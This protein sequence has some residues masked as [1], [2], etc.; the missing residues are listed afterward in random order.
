MAI[1]ITQEVMRTDEF[2]LVPP[3]R[4]QRNTERHS[5]RIVDHLKRAPV[6]TT[7]GVAVIEYSDGSREV[8]DGNSRSYLWRNGRLSRPQSVIV[9]VYHVDTMYEAQSVYFSYNNPISGKDARD[10]VVNS[11]RVHGW[12]PKSAYCQAATLKSPILY[13]QGN[14]MGLK[15]PIKGQ[16]V[17]P[18]LPLWLNELRIFDEILSNGKA[19]GRT[20]TPVVAAC[21]MTLRRH[22]EM[23]IPFWRE[24]FSDGWRGGGID[25]PMNKLHGYIKDR[26]RNFSSSTALYKHLEVVVYIFER[27]LKGDPVIQQIR[28]VSLIDGAYG[29]TYCQGQDSTEEPV[30]SRVVFTEKERNAALF[31]SID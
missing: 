3:Y 19:R 27:W 11:M 13:A 9:T 1:K 14:V 10:E 4:G 8:V 21:L 25:W 24:W 16:S 26:E 31:A 29:P 15:G 28:N 2:V 6:E 5:N 7:A 30:T 12:E 23:A 22:G 20:M 17:F 18:Y